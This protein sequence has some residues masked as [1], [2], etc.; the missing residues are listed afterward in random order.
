M[1]QNTR[2][3]TK[4]RRSYFEVPIMVEKKWS[5]VPS[6]DADVFML[7]IEDSCPPNL[8]VEAR[9]RIVELIGDPGYLG[10]REYIVRPNNLST[11]W[12]RA[13]LEAIAA[14]KVP[15]VIYP[16][17]RSVD[18]MRE[19]K[20]VFDEHGATPEIMLII[21]TP[22]AVLQLEAIASC[23]G[24]TGLLMGPGDLSMET[25]IS[26]LHGGDEFSA[27][28]LYARSKIVLVAS[29]YGLQ[30]TDAFFP[31]DLKDL[32]LM[33]RGMET[34]R[35][36]G[37]TGLMSFY[38]PHVPLINEVMSPSAEEI[39]WS[40]RLVETYRKGREDGLAAITLDGR[41]LTVHQYTTAQET[42]RRAELIRQRAA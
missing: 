6:I 14:A 20:R 34:S 38:P 39:S 26:Q 35:R 3:R 31:A 33:R 15:F 7:D 27:A 18:E 30:P 16:K 41:W 21:E 25:G 19:V 37:F 12:G 4:V 28:F 13:D 1:N 8:K 9:S 2:G 32:A 11:E 10:G 24:V 5:K 36:L 22:Q 17:V 42:L 40:E 23:P 29:A